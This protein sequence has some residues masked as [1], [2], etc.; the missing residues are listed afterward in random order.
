MNIF[1]KLIKKIRKHHAVVPENLV[2]VIDPKIVPHPERYYNIIKRC[3]EETGCFTVHSANCIPL[4][5]GD[6]NYHVVAKH[7]Y[8]NPPWEEYKYGWSDVSEI[9]SCWADNGTYRIKFTVPPYKLRPD[10][11]L[12]LLNGDQT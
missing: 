4:I 12:F 7:F 1:K 6:T 10:Q 11:Y 5:L 2:I 8:I 3:F 9:T